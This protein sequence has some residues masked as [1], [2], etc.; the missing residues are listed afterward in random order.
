MLRASTGKTS[1]TCLVLLMWFSGPCYDYTGWPGSNTFL[2]KRIMICV[3]Y[4]LSTCEWDL[5]FSALFI[6]ENVVI[7]AIERDSLKF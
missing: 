2:Q 4:F 7:L 3:V 5:L 6:C 1:I